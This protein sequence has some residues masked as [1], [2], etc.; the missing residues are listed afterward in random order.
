MIEEDSI[1]NKHS[2]CFTIVNLIVR[3]TA[4]PLVLLSFQKL[5]KKKYIYIYIN[6]K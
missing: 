4:Q 2:I 3:A 1:R 5:K 6:Q